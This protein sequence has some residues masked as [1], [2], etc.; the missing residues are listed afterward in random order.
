MLNEP[1][2][3]CMYLCL[4]LELHSVYPSLISDL[5]VTCV[6]VMNVNYFMTSGDMSFVT[7]RTQQML[8]SEPVLD[9]FYVTHELQHF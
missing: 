8:N 2:R 1:Y 6:V 5:G 3:A 7:S 4:C 9:I